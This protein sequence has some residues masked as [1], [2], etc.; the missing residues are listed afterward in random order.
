[1]RAVFAPVDITSMSLTVI[2]MRSPAGVVSTNESPGAREIERAIARVV[3]TRRQAPYA[4]GLRG[5]HEPVDSRHL[6][7]RPAVAYDRPRYISSGWNNGRGRS[8]G[9]GPRYVRAPANDA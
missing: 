8:F 9:V 1:M 4:S 3:G 6:F 7:R 5:D 2:A